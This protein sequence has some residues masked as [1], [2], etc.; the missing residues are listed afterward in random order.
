MK[1][2]Q[3]KVTYLPVGC[4]KNLVSLCGVDIGIPNSENYDDVLRNTIV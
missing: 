2:E 1:V 3:I 4:L